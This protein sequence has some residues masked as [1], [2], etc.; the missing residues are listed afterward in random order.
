MYSTISKKSLDREDDLHDEG[1]GV[2]LTIH[3]ACWCYTRFR[4]LLIVSRPNVEEF[5]CGRHACKGSGYFSSSIQYILVVLADLYS[6]D[7]RSRR[8]EHSSE[9]I[10]LYSFRHTKAS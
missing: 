5:S 6:H 10:Q 8:A 7:L 4:H 3:H 9:R 2:L 1:K